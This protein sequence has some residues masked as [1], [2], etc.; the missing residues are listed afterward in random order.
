MELSNA[1]T[2]TD[3]AQIVILNTVDEA[4]SITVASV[5]NGVRGVG[6]DGRCRGKM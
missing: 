6:G 3:S 5:V 4:H 1:S 2:I